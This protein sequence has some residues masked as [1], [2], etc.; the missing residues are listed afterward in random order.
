MVI[1]PIIVHQV[2]HFVCFEVQ[3]FSHLQQKHHGMVN[4]SVIGAITIATFL[5]RFCS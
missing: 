3:Y 2:K 4:M 1:V 5:M